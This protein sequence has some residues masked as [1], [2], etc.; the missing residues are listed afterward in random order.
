M[1]FG[2]LRH[3][4]IRLMLPQLV[5]LGLSLSA[6][7]VRAQEQSSVIRLEVDATTL[8]KKILSARE[9]FPIASAAAQ[10]VD[11]VYPKWIPGNHAPT[12]PIADLVNL[13]FAAD[14]KA[15]AWTRDAVDMYRFHIPVP[16]G[17]KTLVADFSLV[18][19]YVP[20]NDFAI[21][22]T[23]TPVQGDVN[24][25]Q[26]ALYPAD[27]KADLVT[28]AASIKLPQKWSYATA[29]THASVDDDGF[30]ADVW[31]CHER[32]RHHS[33]GS[34]AAAFPRSV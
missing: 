4:Y 32:V 10:T 14:G 17:S 23:S 31:L 2:L 24:W 27:T 13:R 12:G 29:L 11:L 15:V 5:C 22:N 33:E 19:A 25:D 16:A 21:G 34:Q 18:G 1:S 20:D 28:I 26:V 8:P 6:T 30:T 9:S 7:C 3:S